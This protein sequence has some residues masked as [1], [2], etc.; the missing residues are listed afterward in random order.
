MIAALAG[1]RI[2]AKDSAAT[3]FPLK[4]APAVADRIRSRFQ[5]LAISTLV[6]AAARGADLLALD[7]AGELSI[8]R[9]VV[10]PGNAASFRASSVVDGL[11]GERQDRNG[12]GPIFDRIHEEVK[13]QGD[14]V[15]CASEAVGHESYVAANLVILDQ[16]ASLAASTG[17]DLLA[18]LVWDLASRGPNDITAAFRDEAI[19]RGIRIEEISTL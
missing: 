14:L 1:R 4:N 7:V 5:S 10:L 18:I 15:I 11:T 8:R 19:K 17:E 16:A 6:C 12:W 9:C 3:R 2:D 13:S